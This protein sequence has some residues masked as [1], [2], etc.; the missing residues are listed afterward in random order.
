MR[1]TKEEFN[2]LS[3]LDRIE[4]RQ[5]RDDIERDRGLSIFPNMCWYTLIL[6]AIFGVGGYILTAIRFIILFVVIMVAYI[7]MYLIVGVA[8]SYQMRKLN[9]EYFEVKRT[10][11]WVS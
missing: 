11:K 3:Q 1:I 9:E 4:Y 6:I 5:K 2:K 7:F 8:Q 10:K